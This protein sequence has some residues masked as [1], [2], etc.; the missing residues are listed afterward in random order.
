MASS[1][2]DLKWSNGARAA[3]AFTMDNMGEAADLDRGLWP[4]SE[5]IGSHHSVKSVIPQILPILRK[6]NVRATYFVESW[7]LSVYP[8]A[9]AN[10]AKE[11]HEIAWHAWRHE[12]WGKLDEAAERNSFERSFGSEGWEGFKASHGANSTGL[13]RYHGFRPPGGVIHGDRTLRLCEQYGLSYISPAGEEA[14]VVK[15]DG[16]KENVVV[17]PFKWSTVDAL[18]YM[19]AFG[20][21]RKLKSLPEEVQTTETLSKEYMREIDQAIKNGGYVSLL[22]HPFLTDRPERMQALEDVIDYLVQ[23]RDSGE[24]WLARCQDIADWIASHPSRFG[25]DPGLDSSSWR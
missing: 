21:L 19:E 14:A 25:D 22:F 8:D 13:D 5:P 9:V 17:L 10:I 24:I 18:Y 11:G 1:E 12:A 16:S 7:N 15:L 23:K 6:H 2:G 3:I 20:G 4:E